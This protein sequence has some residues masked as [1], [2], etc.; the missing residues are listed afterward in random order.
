LSTVVITGASSGIGRAVALALAAPGATL[1]LIGRDPQRLDDMARDVS[2]KGARA[3]VHQKDLATEMPKIDAADTLIHAAG[4]VKLGAVESASLADL[5]AQ[6]AINVRAPFALTQHLLPALIAAKGQVVFINSGA[7]LNARAGWSQYAMTKFALR[8]LADALRE[9]VK[10]KGV[11][12]M[13]VYPGR[14]A[15][16]MQAEVHRQEGK[17]YDPSRFIQ[18]E[19]VATMIVQALALPR[20]AQVTEINIRHQE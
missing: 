3:I 5:D 15:T 16:P 14:T 12:V 18:P 10:S 2:T 11:R 9:E 19:D 17:T 1:H 8:A 20:S 7:G 6:Y 4:T 13:T